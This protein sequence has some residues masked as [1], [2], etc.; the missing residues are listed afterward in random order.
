MMSNSLNTLRKLKRDLMYAVDDSVRI[1][2]HTL[3]PQSTIVNQKEIRVVGL[4]RSG[5]HAIINWIAKQQEGHIKHLNNLMPGRNPYRFLYEHYPKLNLAREVRGQFSQKDCL[6]Y[7]YENCQLYEVVDREFEWKHDIYLGKSQERYDVLILRDPFNML[8]S[9]LHRQAKQSK[10]QGEIINYYFKGKGKNKIQ[11]VDIIE[12]WISYAKEYLRETQYLNQNKV[13][14][15]YN[16]WATNVDYRKEIAEQLKLTFS[17]RGIQEVRRYGGGSSF[18]GLERD[19]QATTMDVLNRWKTLADDPDYR[20][21]MD[22]PAAFEYSERIF[23]HIPG[24]ECLL[25]N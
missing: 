22:N 14:I 15:N 11:N 6:I 19:G 18:E 21:L 17:D 9:E 2:S 20:R 16:L 5:N 1:V 8:A 24:T 3:F 7:S 10:G 13:T 25:P 4:K 23:G 12:L